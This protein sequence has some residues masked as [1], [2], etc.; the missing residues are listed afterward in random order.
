MSRSKRTKPIF[1]NTTSHSEKEDKKIW[2]R[3]LRHISKQKLKDLE[4]SFP[5]RKEVSD[6]WDMAKDGKHYWFNCP[7][8]KMSK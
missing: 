7:K 4:P 3:K 2:H 8:H 1:G 6:P 5:D